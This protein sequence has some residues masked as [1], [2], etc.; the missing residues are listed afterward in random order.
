M[1][2]LLLLVCACLLVIQNWAQERT[3]TGKVTDEKAVPLPNVTVLIKGTKKVVTT[4]DAGTFRVTAAQGATLILSLV[5]YGSQEVK[6]GTQSNFNVT[7]HATGQN[8]SDVVVTALA[9]T[10]SKRSL[11]YATQ[12]IKSDEIA[13]KGDGSLLNALQGKVAGA[14]ITSAGGSAG[15]STNIILRG[16]TTFSGSNQPLF[17]VD[18]IPISNDLDQ[19]TVS[20]YTDQSANRAMDLNLNNVESVNVLSGPAA[21]ALYG[22]RASNG[23]IIITTKK[24]V[25][26]KGAVSVT[27]NSSYTAQKIY[28]FPEL[29]NEYGQGANG[30]FSA[31]STNSWGPKFGS[32]PTLANG[33]IVAPGTSPVVNGRKYNP[34]ETI[35]YKAYPNNIL[36]FFE[37]GKVVENNLSINA[38][39]AQ[40]NYTLSIGNS[41][42]RGIIPTTKFDRTNIQFSASSQ[43]TDKLSVKGSATYFSTVQ[44]SATQGANSSYGS[45]TRVYST[46]RSI[47]MEYY[48]N[49]YTTP[50]GYNNWF[51]PNT[52][53]TGLKDT[54]SGGDNPYYALNKNPIT[55]HTARI[56]GSFTIGYNVADWLNVSYRAGVDAYTTRR[57]RVTAI[58]STQIVRSVFT[59]AAGTATGGVMEDMYYRNEINGDLMITAK[60]NDIFTKGLNA[61]LLLG[62]NINQVK[63]QQISEVGYGLTV[64]GYYNI[65]NA[66]NFS[67]SNEYSSTRR[68]LGFYGQLSLAY[69]NYLFLELTGRVDNSSTLPKKNNTY[70]YPAANTSL[71]LTDAIP[72]LK[73]DVLSFAKVRLG[74]AR[75]GKDA[76]VYS[77]SNTFYSYALG[78]NVAS[79]NFPYGTTAGFGASNVIANPN[80]TPEFTTSKEGGFNLGLFKNNL[81]IDFT[82]YSQ[83]SKDQIVS[84]GLAGSTGYSSKVA[85]VGRMTN[86]GIELTVSGTPVKTKDFSWNVSGNFTKNKNKVQYVIADHSVK[87]FQIGGFVYSGLIP[88]IVEG[89]PFGV[90][91]GSKFLTNSKGERLIDSTTGNYAGY[92][93]NQIVA[94]P[95]RDWSAG[96]TNTFNYKRFSFSFLLDYKQ[97]GDIVSFTVSTLRANGSL[98]ET[99]VDRDLPKVLPGVI[100][101]A[102]G[103]YVQ[104]NIQVPS[105]TYWNGSFGSSTGAS[106]SN[107]FAVFDATTFRVREVS[108]G[109]EFVGDVIK[110]GVLKS[111]RLSIYGRNLFF[112]APNSPID[113]EMNTQGA[114]NIRGLELLSAPNTRNYGAALR[115]TL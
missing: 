14:D 42:N 58:G 31:I 78:N 93:A 82:Y 2:K 46:P 33:L 109:Y 23:A 11:G 60:K 97:G 40:N 16:M 49:N 35:E 69:N 89:Q 28:G 108:L 15:A 37:T 85:N 21:A 62:Q 53:S 66:T 34:G 102:D 17:V 70:F 38:G 54:I 41:N 13:D 72:S 18:G 105:Q 80:L 77:T 12:T 99:A 67:L 63:S 20:L 94:N 87:S 65:T 91:L 111:V 64:P 45:T 74:W 90:V 30:V 59:G 71:V 83:L 24:G 76:A 25:G 4:D 113:P 104:N 86:K 106:T 19:G 84:V 48:K 100:A 101:R 81:N 79:F 5:G 55:S 51:L 114:G 57:K 68:L 3:V 52:Y 88:S 6:V 112:Y 9:I 50:G 43:L 103:S 75:V 27:Y 29:Q 98:K 8:L 10:K 56:L 32:T 47:D 39:D 36:N 44:N 26:K 22:S 107:E 61:N 73:S 95:N 96:L 92:L 7:L 110:S 1:R 115:V